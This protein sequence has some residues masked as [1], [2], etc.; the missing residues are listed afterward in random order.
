MRRVKGRERKWLARN[1][2]AGHLKR[3]L[4]Y[5]AATKK[6]L[7]MLGASG[8]M[9]C[10]TPKGAMTRAS[11]L[12]WGLVLG[13]YSASRGRRGGAWRYVSRSAVDPADASRTWC[14]RILTVA[15]RLLWEGEYGH[16]GR[17]MHA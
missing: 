15:T 3:R 8:T 2:K 1:T 11:A 4:E 12:R 16:F 5:H 13:D 6:Q 7:P 10:P 17:P 14:P 9:Y